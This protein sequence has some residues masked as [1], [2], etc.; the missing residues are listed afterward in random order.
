MDSR[1]TLDYRFKEE[2][3]LEEVLEG[4]EKLGKWYILDD[5]TKTEFISVNTQDRCI[6]SR[7]MTGKIG[8]WIN[9]DLIEECDSG[10]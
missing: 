4:F 3:N 10:E 9:S 6:I 1:L 5:S 7:G 8:E 2:I